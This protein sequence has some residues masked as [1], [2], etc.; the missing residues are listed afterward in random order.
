VADWG[1]FRPAN[2]G[3][4]DQGVDYSG[5]GRIPALGPATVTDV[6]RASIIEGGSYPYVVYQLNGGPF[7]GRYV[8][9]AENFR[10]SVRAGQH[11]QMG[12]TLGHAVGAFPYIEVGFNQRAQGWDAYGS[13][14]AGPTP[15]GR[16]MDAYVTS[17]STGQPLSGQQV[18]GAATGGNPLG[19]VTG[20]VTA[21]VHA[22]MSV[23]DL[24]GK[25]LDPHF[26]LRA[27]EVVGGFLI[28][29]L[30][31]YLLSRQAGLA[32]VPEP[33]T[34]GLSEETLASLQEPPGVESY[35]P[36]YRRSTEG[37]KRDVVR[38]DVSEAGSR[39]KAIRER[40]ERARPDFGDVPY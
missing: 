40:S 22:A 20:V 31:L 39:R 29:F 13:P 9:V 3:R 21:P 32:G 10:P 17:V 38:H 35:R 5:S 11:L 2:R 23:A 8:Y 26:W 15:A 6:G 28:L 18:L 37:V 34:P 7:S 12:Q 1:V 25:L 27:L 30:G 36:Q 16:V 24:I 4:I 14:T 33:P 19:G